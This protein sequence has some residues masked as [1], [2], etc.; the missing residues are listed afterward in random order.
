[1]DRGN[2]W[3][4]RLG[5]PLAAAVTLVSATLMPSV[6]RAAPAGGNDISWPQCGH[7]YPAT[8]AFGIVGVDDG[9]PNT[10]NPCLASEYQ[11]AR[12]S[13][14]V[15][16]YMN[17]SN[18]GLAAAD[19]YSYGYSAARY[20]LS[21]AT[22]QVSPG[23]GH[24]WWI[25]VETGNSWSPDQGANTADIAGSIAF[26]RAEGVTVG[27]YSTVH[28]WGVITGGAIIP[29]VPNWV[30]GAPSAALAPSFCAAS[31]SFSGGPVVL[32]QYT[33]QFDNDHV[34]PG[35]SLAPPASGAGS[36]LGGLVSNL[37]AWLNSL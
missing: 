37:L 6:A 36:G 17:S 26:F 13:G 19:A 5:I 18:P 35:A 23:R 16:F 25:D 8:P 9:Q 2:R 12:A 3:R 27:I 31:K 22:S 29:S 10:A 34:C 28:Q 30:P 32:T 24:V 4:W 14:I 11:W 21:Y 1:M 7:A 15:E 20:A 33:T